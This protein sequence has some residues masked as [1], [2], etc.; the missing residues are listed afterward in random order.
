M[1]IGGMLPYLFSSYAL[2]AVEKAAHKMVEEVRR[3]FREIPGIMEGKAEPEYEKCVDISTQGALKEMIIPSLITIASPFVMV[4]LFGK[5]GLG[6]FLAGALVSGALLAIFMAN[7][8]GAWDNAKKLIERGLF[9]G[10]GSPAHKAAVTG[11]TVGDPFKDTAG[12][13][14]NILLKLMSII[15]LVFLPFFL[16]F[17]H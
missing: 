2:S 7:A 15:S 3:Q 11:D 6:G 1:F 17:L 9:G 5:D 16:R 10:K 14:I 12:P 8:G 4:F 13:S